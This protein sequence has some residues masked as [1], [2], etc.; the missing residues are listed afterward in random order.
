MNELLKNG[1]LGKGRFVGYAS[2][3]RDV[4]VRQ[5]GW[6]NAKAV[7][8]V[9]LGSKIVGPTGPVLSLSD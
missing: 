8:L 6:F 2:Q 1:R 4:P 3:R 9:R 7:C 5:G